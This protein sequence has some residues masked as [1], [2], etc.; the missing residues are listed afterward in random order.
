M[1]VK[2]TNSAKT[3]SFNLTPNKASALCY[4]PLVGW[5][6]AVVLLLIEKHAS[7]R[8]DAVQSLMISGVV[9]A[10]VLV[11]N[12]VLSGAASVV[13]VV[14]QLVLAVKAYQGESYRLP[15]V[16]DWVDKLVK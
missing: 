15:V 13:A 12:P 16:A 5:V 6:A 1:P 7:V 11:L 14:L 3:V 9:V 4:V 10:L 8:W 2:K